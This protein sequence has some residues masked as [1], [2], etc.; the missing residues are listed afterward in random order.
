MNEKSKSYIASF[1]YMD[2]E[3]NDQGIGSILIHQDEYQPITSAT[4]RDMEN[5]IRE[6]YDYSP[7]VMV[8]VTGFFRLE[9][10]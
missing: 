2:V 3:T 6:T 10:D 5:M 1:I 9:A 7:K 4:I 8:G